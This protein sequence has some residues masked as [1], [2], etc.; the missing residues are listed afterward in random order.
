MIKVNGDFMI[1]CEKCG[2]MYFCKH[3][4]LQAVQS[5]KRPASPYQSGQLQ[6]WRRCCDTPYYRDGRNEIDGGQ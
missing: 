3:E 5:K 6:M 4:N 1:R 2:D